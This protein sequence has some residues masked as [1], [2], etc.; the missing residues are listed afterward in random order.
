MAE[1]KR[2]LLEEIVALVDEMTPEQA[3]IAAGCC[4]EVA[5]VMSALGTGWRT[6][7]LLKVVVVECLRVLRSAREVR[8]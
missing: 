7:R 2:V 6:K 5:V 4:C 3:D 1:T 8:P